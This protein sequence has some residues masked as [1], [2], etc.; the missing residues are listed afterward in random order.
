MAVFHYVA[1]TENDQVVKGMYQA[2]DKFTVIAMLKNKGYI[3]L[4]V[5][6]NRGLGIN[7]DFIQ[8]GITK[9]D[10]AVFCR[11]F[12]A[13]IEAGIPVLECLDIVRK[14]TESRQLKNVLNNVYEQVQKGRALSD[15]FKEFRSVLPAVLINMIEAGEASGTLDRVMARL[16]VYFENESKVVNKVKGAMIYPMVIF[17]VAIAAVIVLL[18]LVVP[19]FQSMFSSMGAELPVLTKMLISASGFVVN[20]IFLLLIFIIALII[21]AL[22]YFKSSTG[23][24]VLDKVY[25]QIPII[26]NMYRKMITARFTRTMASLLSAGLPLIQALE[27]TNKVLDNAVMTKQLDKVVEDITK[28]SKLSIAISQVPVFPV[29]LI[30]MI[31]IGEESGSMD[32]VLDKVA[33]FYE[34]ETEVAVGKLT[35]MLEPAIIIVMAVIVGSVVLGVAMPMF[36]MIQNVGNMTG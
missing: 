32:S 11:Q 30:S 33:D 36:Q 5:K 8:T 14:Q 24:Q 27:I 31:G 15:G 22:Y 12:S 17:V 1:R 20:N 10:I 25:L 6:E 34:D 16:A 7:L 4:E 19:Q 9:R 35:S 18:W 23:K 29:M 3:P 21:G 28:G 2:T 13:V 26:S